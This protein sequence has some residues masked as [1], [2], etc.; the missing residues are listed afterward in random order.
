MLEV[1]GSG[2]RIGSEK[3]P[4]AREFQIWDAMIKDLSD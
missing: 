1:Q 4:P 3:S 2:P